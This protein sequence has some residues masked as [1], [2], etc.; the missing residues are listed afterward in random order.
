MRH[1]E[2]EHV[3]A[4]RNS[5]APKCCH[6]CEHYRSDGVCVIFDM[7]PPEDYAAHGSEHCEHWIEMIPF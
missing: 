5:R 4:W 2:P 7:E 3:I 1:K 6:L